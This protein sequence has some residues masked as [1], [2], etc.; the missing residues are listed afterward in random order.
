ME[1]HVLLS[2]GLT[3]VCDSMSAESEICVIHCNDRRRWGSLLQAAVFSNDIWGSVH[4][5][6]NNGQTETWANCVEFNGGLTFSAGAQLCAA[7]IENVF[8]GGFKGA[9]ALNNVNVIFYHR[10]E[11]P[12]WSIGFF[13]ILKTSVAQLTTCLLFLTDLPHNG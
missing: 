12:L 8:E 13:H 3:S 2:P 10:D 9:M 5:T 4:C 6:W 7:A 1:V 11:F